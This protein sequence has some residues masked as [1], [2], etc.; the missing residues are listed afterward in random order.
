M[1]KFSLVSAVPVVLLL[2]A[3]GEAPAPG[4]EAPAAPAAVVS[5]TSAPSATA[6]TGADAPAQLPAIISAP[7]A[8]TL[9]SSGQL[10]L[11]DVRTPREW[12]STGI[13]E[14][15]ATI[16]MRERD[17]ADRVLAAVGGD[18]TTPIALTCAAGGRSSSSARKLRELGFTNVTDI[19]EGFNGNQTAGPGWGA[20]GLPVEA[21]IAE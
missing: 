19:S 21:Y 12:R 18:K 14:G 16:N 2:G 3:C 1:H 6:P 11:I 10:K 8:Y 5:E 17:F 20:R 13:P 7:D 4:S 9:A 15:A